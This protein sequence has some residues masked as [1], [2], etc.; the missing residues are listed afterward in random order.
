MSYD[1]ASIAGGWARA[2]HAAA[3]RSAP[4]AG[5][6]FRSP[7]RRSPTPPGPGRPSPIP[8]GRGECR[9]RWCG[10]RIA[11]ELRR[12]SRRS[13]FRLRVRS[14]SGTPRR[15]VRSLSVRGRRDLRFR[16]HG[17]P[18]GGRRLRSGSVPARP[19]PEGA[20]RGWA[21]HQPP[22]LGRAR[23]LRRD[24]LPPRGRSRCRRAIESARLPAS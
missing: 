8:N 9:F 1:R 16:K 7:P 15:D 17:S 14:R 18:V 24:R 12:V 19:S 6:I 21:S 20:P 23:R 2:A 22:G 3:G 4:P 5:G 13:G 10:R 11:R